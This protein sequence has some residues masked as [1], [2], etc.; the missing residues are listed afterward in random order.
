MEEDRQVLQTTCRKGLG[1]VPIREIVEAVQKRKG[2]WA[3]ETLNGPF[4]SLGTHSQSSMSGSLLFSAKVKQPQ[5]MV[6]G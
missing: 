5:V 1:A 3:N 2:C 6:S 4:P